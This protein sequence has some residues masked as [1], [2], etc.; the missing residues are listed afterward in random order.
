MHT[1]TPLKYISIFIYVYID[2]YISM[3][4]CVKEASELLGPKLLSILPST[5]FLIYSQYFVKVRSLLLYFPF[6]KK[7]GMSHLKLL[8]LV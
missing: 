8:K 3:D 6:K 2:T 1:H 4:A 5:V 7:K